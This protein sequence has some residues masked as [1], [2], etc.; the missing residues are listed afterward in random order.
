MAGHG[1]WGG[2]GFGF[3]FILAAQSGIRVLALG[4]PEAE[5][6]KARAG[7]RKLSPFGLSLKSVTAAGAITWGEAKPDAIIPAKRSVAQVER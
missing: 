4:N 2:F 5:G 7:R 1:C 3:I 6:R